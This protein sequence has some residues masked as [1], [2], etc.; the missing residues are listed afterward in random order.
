MRAPTVPDKRAERLLD[1]VGAAVALTFA[2][3][4][5][6]AVAV[7]VRVLDG[8]PVLFRQRRVGRHGRPF[9]LLKFRT[10]VPDAEAR[11][12]ELT[13]RNEADGPLFKIRDDPRTTPLGRL[14]R[15]TSIDE[16]PQ[17][18]NVLRGDMSLV[19][20]RPALPEEVAAWPA[21]LHRR[22]DV[23]P[24]ITGPWQVAGR[25]ASS[26]EDYRRHDLAYVDGRTLWGDLALLARTVPA[27]LRGRG[28]S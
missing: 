24:G 21:D 13:D 28:A 26:F 10:M 2:A 25:S 14:L 15:R 8:P 6:A 17:L 3:L 11:R 7:L 4:P 18:W 23:R 9:T 1:V 5:I 27:V 19:G 22:L 20:P 16:L 12:A